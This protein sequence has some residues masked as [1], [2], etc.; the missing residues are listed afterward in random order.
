[1][2]KSLIL[3]LCFFSENESYLPLVFT[4]QSQVAVDGILSLYSQS[5]DLTLIIWGVGFREVIW[6]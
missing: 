1:M 3:L 5:P 6:P 2:L 4:R